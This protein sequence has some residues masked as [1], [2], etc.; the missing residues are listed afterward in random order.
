MPPRKILLTVFSYAVPIYLL[1]YV[2]SARN[3][4][5]LNDFAERP[6]AIAMRRFRGRPL[7]GRAILVR[8]LSFLAL[9]IICVLMAWMV[10][11]TSP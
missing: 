2:D 11:G 5:R 4:R 9:A 1:L 3:G 8:T 7:T 6:R 10:Y